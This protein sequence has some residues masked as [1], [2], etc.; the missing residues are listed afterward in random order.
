M[1][2]GDDIMSTAI[3]KAVFES[4]QEEGESPQCVFGRPDNFHDPKTGKL[5]VYWSEMFENNPYILQPGGQ[6]DYLMCIPDFPGCRQYIDYETCTIKQV[7]DK[8][9]KLHST[10]DAFSFEKEFKAPKGEIYFSDLEV[11][12]AAALGSLP[13]IVVEPNV[14]G[15]L[16]S[17]KAWGFERWQSLIN[18]LSTDYHFAQFQYPGARLLDGV[19]YIQTATFRSALVYLSCASGFIGTDGGLHHAA[20]A[21]SKKAIVLWSHYSSPVNLGYDT[22]V[23]IR[24]EGVDGPCGRTYDCKECRAAMDAITTDEVEE[25]FRI[26]FK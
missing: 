13:T 25:V 16:G 11:A 2:W 4:Y 21:L 17:N 12:Q 1:G 14:K 9:N 15:L 3:A 6:S 24:A 18:S 7:L 8:N 5:N 19:E 10:I 26:S 22:H 23:N 20:A